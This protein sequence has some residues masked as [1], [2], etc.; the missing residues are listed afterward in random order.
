MKNW[1]D[2]LN[3]GEN[4][5]KFPLISSKSSEKVPEKSSATL[6]FSRSSQDRQQNPEYRRCGAEIWLF[7]ETHLHL[8]NLFS[9]V[10]DAFSLSHISVSLPLFSDSIH[11][12]HRHRVTGISMSHR[13]CR[14]GLLFPKQSHIIAFL[15]RET[16]IQKL[17]NVI[18][19]AVNLIRN[20]NQILHILQYLLTRASIWRSFNDIIT[21]DKQLID[22]VNKN[23]NIKY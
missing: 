15:E 14:P 20:V 7:A 16:M 2:G 4:R 1:R 9:S 18:T 6:H 8:Y 19:G 11:F 13:G 3:T 10:F 21:A 22:N 12:C 23:K 5:E 17:L